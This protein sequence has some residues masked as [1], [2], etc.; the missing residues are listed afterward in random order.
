MIASIEVEQGLNLD[1]IKQNTINK[2]K[3]T[4]WNIAF[5]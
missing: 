3:I 2:K 5:S 1:M 4:N